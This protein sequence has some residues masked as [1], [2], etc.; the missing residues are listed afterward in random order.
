MQRPLAVMFIA[1]ILAASVALAEPPSRASRYQQDMGAR[2]GRDGADGD[3]QHGQP[4]ERG[5]YRG[6]SGGAYSQRPAETRRPDPAFAQEHERGPR[7]GA[8]QNGRPEAG[9][10]YREH[11]DVQPNREPS[12]GQA[13]TPQAGQWRNADRPLQSDRRGEDRRDGRDSRYPRPG[14]GD[15]HRDGRENYQNAGWDRDR[16]G[17]RDERG[18]RWHHDR[19]WYDS[20]RDDHFR[21]YGNRYYA[22]QRFS[23]GFYYAPWGYSTRYWERGDRLPLSYYGDRYVI[24]DYYD[25]DLYAPP[26]AT[27]WVRVGND[28]LLIDMDTGEV[29]DIVA[30]LF[31]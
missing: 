15:G 14:Y 8:S 23:I 1:S 2:H 16:H 11:A 5:E 12:R 18:H 4:R 31:W 17:W 19:D 30:D 22:R 25:Y 27:A 29:L 20:Y 24:Y 6:S 9:S 28:V 21:F 10:R 13:Y 3:R 7:W 26:Y